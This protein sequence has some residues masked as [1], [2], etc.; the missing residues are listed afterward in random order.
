MLSDAGALAASGA[1][2]EDDFRAAIEPFVR[3]RRRALLNGS[4]D[5]ST[6][7]WGEI[8][9]C[10][11]AESNPYGPSQ[12]TDS[13]RMD[14]GVES[15][16][17]NG[18]SRV[19]PQP[20]LEVLRQST[21][22]QNMLKLPVQ[23]LDPKLYAAL[24]AVLKDLGGKWV[25][26]KVQAH[27]FEP[28]A[29]PGLQRAIASGLFV[30][31][32]DVGLFPTPAELADALVAFAQIIPGMK[33][34]EP[35]AG[36]GALALRAA[37]LTSSLADVTVCELL[38]ANVRKLRECGFKDVRELD[39]LALSPVPE[40]DRVVMNPPFSRGVDIDHF[41]HAAKF[42]KPE[43]RIVA[44]LSTSW[45]RHSAAKA[46]AFRELM[47]ECDAQM[48]PIPAGAFKAAGTQVATVMVGVDAVNFPWNQKPVLSE[49]MRA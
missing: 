10:F 49:R 20:V 25:G 11:P 1:P 40:F 16:V 19:V 37:N 12:S 35:S 9:A 33:I 48:E 28:D 39:F 34:L 43:G 29:I 3:S 42:L 45:Q 21:V 41:L 14:V 38:H 44:I 31:L 26:K 23:R 36:Y 30:R 47:Q 13:A 5:L 22:E 17:D 32:K 24:S 4:A 2:S 27:V 6:V 7:C 8:A 18:V 15:E 46:V